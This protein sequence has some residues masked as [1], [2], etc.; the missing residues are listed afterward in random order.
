MMKDKTSLKIVAVSVTDWLI[1]VRSY[2]NIQNR[3][4]RQR[5]L[6]E[7]A[8]GAYPWNARHF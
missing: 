2:N 4:M 8:L 5:F 7:H 3:F 1:R 6:Y